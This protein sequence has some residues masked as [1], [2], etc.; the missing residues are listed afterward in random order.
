MPIDCLFFAPYFL[1]EV[2]RSR[3]RILAMREINTS[4]RRSGFGRV[5]LIAGSLR[6]IL[7]DDLT[8]SLFYHQGLFPLLRMGADGRMDR[9]SSFRGTCE[10]MIRCCVLPRM[11]L[12][13]R[14]YAC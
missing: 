6:E 5:C 2:F 12:V 11:S 3:Y 14:P 7:C 9:P 4:V 1:P 10:T 13:R 8:W